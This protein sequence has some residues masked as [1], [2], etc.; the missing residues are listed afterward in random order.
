M[1]LF[2]KLRFLISV[3][4]FLLPA[5]NISADDCKVLDRIAIT[6]ASVTAGMGLKTPPISSDLGGY[7]MNFQHV[8]EGMLEIEPEA[9]GFF[10]DVMFFRSSRKN[11][12]EYVQKIVEF[13]PTIVFGID[14]LFWF[15]YGMAPD[16]VDEDEYRMEKLN[17]GLDLLELIDAPII[18]G[19]LPDMHAAIGYMLRDGQVPSVPTISKLNERI[20]KW[21]EEHKNVQVISVY[22]LGK[23]ILGNEEFTILEH[24]WP[25]GSRAR[26][27]QGDLLHTTL[28]GT[29]AAALLVIDAIDV[30]CF[31][32]DPKLI[33]QK[34]AQNAREDYAESSSGT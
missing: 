20:H 3:S 13:K 16:D 7:P 2:M 12:T 18:V 1:I 29:T 33:M 9:I 11:A 26:L 10:A 32:R 4:I 24:T 21:A 34:A 14:F 15:G 30:E 5:Q 22:E 17:F 31:K 27:M 6:G 19:D 23:H 25:A 8:V 28:E